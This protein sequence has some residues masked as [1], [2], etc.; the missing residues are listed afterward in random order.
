MLDVDKPPFEVTETGW[1]EFDIQIKIF[2]VPEA[3]E[4]PVTFFHHL[5]LHP[6][7]AGLT[8][9][10]NNLVPI[11]QAP[12]ET[13]PAA[14]AGEGSVGSAAAE[15]SAAVGRTP[16]PAVAEPPPAPLPVVRTPVHS[17]QYDEVVF[18]EPTESLYNILVQHPPTPLY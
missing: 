18:N 12:A 11:P 14:A 15:G 8:L 2:F 13:A 4:K 1:G 7:P 9:G 5:K 6:W 16:A 10:P 17:W 3:N